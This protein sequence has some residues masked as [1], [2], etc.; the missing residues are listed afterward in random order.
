MSYETA[1]PR[2]TLR[3]TH[4][5]LVYTDERIPEVETVTWPDGKTFPGAML[6]DKDVC[7]EVASLLKRACWKRLH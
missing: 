1:A 6:H 4:L 3:G 5:T 7:P 2:H